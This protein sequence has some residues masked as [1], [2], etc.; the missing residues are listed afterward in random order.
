MG[1][2]RESSTLSSERSTLRAVTMCRLGQVAKFVVGHADVLVVPVADKNG[3]DGAT[4]DATGMM[5]SVD[6][7]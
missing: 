6:V 5:G 2:G 3:S 4:D 7:W 1:G